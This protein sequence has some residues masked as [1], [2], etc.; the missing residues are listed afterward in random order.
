MSLNDL[1]YFSDEVN[2]F[3]PIMKALVDEVLTDLEL[4]QKY[5]LKHH[6]GQDT[7]GIPDFVILDKKTKDYVFVLEVKKTPSDVLAKKYGEQSMNYAKDLSLHWR[8]KSPQYFCVTNFEYT[9]LY[10]LREN[11]SLIGCLQEDSPFVAGSLSDDNINDKFR[12]ILSHLI[13]IIDKKK[14]GF[15]MVRAPASSRIH[16]RC[17]LRCG[18][19]VV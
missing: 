10:C 17:S 7:K 8:N 18:Q 9:Q 3:H 1:S 6:Y 11:S 4:T 2:K 5:I 13:K 16:K 19:C 14:W 15:V 12:S